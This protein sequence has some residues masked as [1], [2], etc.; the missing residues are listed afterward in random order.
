M[1]A[2]FL[3]TSFHLQLNGIF[4]QN[5]GLQN[6]TQFSYAKLCI[7]LVKYALSLDLRQKV[8][9]CQEIAGGYRPAIALASRKQRLLPAQQH[10]VPVPPAY[11]LFAG[12][13]Y[14]HGLHY[15]LCLYDLRSATRALPAPRPHAACM[16][17]VPTSLHK[18]TSSLY[19]TPTENLSRFCKIF[20]IFRINCF[21]VW[22]N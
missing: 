6:R 7:L 4:T 18:T 1:S 10:R 3:N 21:P 19:C 16:S 22:N 11:R 14:L 12:P 13:Y 9:Q 5:S 15:L 8:Y 20:T 2:F 17:P